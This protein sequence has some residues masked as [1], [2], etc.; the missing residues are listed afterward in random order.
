M[1]ELT[2]NPFS[3]IKPDEISVERLEH[4]NRYVQLLYLALLDDTPDSRERSI[5]IT[6]LQEFRMWANASVVF[7]QM[8]T[9]E[10]NI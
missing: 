4:L 8:R 5:A 3:Y 2:P 10:K 9:R 1:P 6:K 7:D